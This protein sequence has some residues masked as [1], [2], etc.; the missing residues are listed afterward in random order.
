MELLTCYSLLPGED[1]VDQLPCMIEL[2][3]MPSQK[4]L[5]ASRYKNNIYVSHISM[6]G[7]SVQGGVNQDFMS[8]VLFYFCNICNKPINSETITIFKRET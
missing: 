7:L 2:L 6:G 1:E 4:M 5:D 8:Y 3:G